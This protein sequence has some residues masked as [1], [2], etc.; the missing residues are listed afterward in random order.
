MPASLEAWQR[1]QHAFSALPEN[2]RGHIQ[3]QHLSVPPEI[4]N[5]VPAEKLSIVD[6]VA[7]KFPGSSDTTPPSGHQCFAAENP[8]LDVSSTLFTTRIPPASI[9]HQ[10]YSQTSQQWPGGTDSV[11]LSGTVE[12]SDSPIWAPKVWETPYTRIYYKVGLRKHG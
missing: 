3:S 11:H 1:V 2:I 7:T 5:P 6:F 9:I 8:V 4:I 10:L 12:H